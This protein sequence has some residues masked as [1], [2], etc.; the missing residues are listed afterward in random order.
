[1]DAEEEIEWHLPS[2]IQV[3]FAVCKYEI[4]NLSIF[5]IAE[6]GSLINRATFLSLAIFGAIRVALDYATSL[7][8]L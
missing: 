6:E 5:S 3:S 1:M 2:R 4:A 7:K 8:S